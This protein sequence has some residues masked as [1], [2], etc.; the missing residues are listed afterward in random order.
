[1]D[2]Q[3]W[4]I[5]KVLFEKKNITKAAQSLYISQPALTRRIQQME[6]E[7][8]V[9][10]IHRG[11]RGVDF[12]PQGEYLAKSADEA[13]EHLRHIK[14]ATTNIGQEVRGTL[15]LGV[16][17]YI[18]K[19][20]LPRLLKL[21]RELYPLVEYKVVT[22]WSREVFDL[23]YNQEI[24]IGIVRGDYQ[25]PDAKL[26]LF[27][28]NICVASRERIELEQLPFMPRIEYQMDPL[29]KGIIDN[30]WS[31]TFSR[32]PLIG[33]EVDKGDTCT[34]MVINGLGYGIL[35]SALVENVD[36]LHRI[37]V[38]DRQEQ[39]IVRQTWMLYHE[40]ALELNVIKC[41]V[42]FVETLDFQKDL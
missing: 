26:F 7:F 9:T 11:T 2:Y 14:E 38:N 8:K 21:F 1:M 19:H 17:N 12:T 36:G 34:E 4:L 16:S 3:D 42:K 35:S 39:P 15:R 23:I 31:G 37:V 20:K 10:I 13:L 6:Q 33:M 18:S 40:H 41:F 29:M 25:W 24:H 22:G 30:W 32:P 5:I 27:E 28:E